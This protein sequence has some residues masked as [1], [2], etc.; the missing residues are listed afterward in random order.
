M[1]TLMNSFDETCESESS[2]NSSNEPA[3]SKTLSLF[4]VLHERFWRL[5]DRILFGLEAARAS[6]SSRELLYLFSNW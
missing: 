2:P 4:F 6:A 3:N 1:I 5:V